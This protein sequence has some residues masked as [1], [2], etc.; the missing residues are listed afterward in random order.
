VNVVAV[1]LI[2]LSTIPV[3]LATRLSRDTGAVAPTAGGA[4]AAGA[5]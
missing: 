3:Y 1:F 5:R 2:L 4:Q